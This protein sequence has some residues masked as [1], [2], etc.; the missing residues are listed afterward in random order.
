MHKE[1]YRE[2]SD[3]LV[4]RVEKAYS[5][6][7]AGKISAKQFDQICDRAEAEQ[8]KNTVSFKTRQYANKFAA[9][10]DEIGPGAAYRTKG[11]SSEKWQPPGV[12]DCTQAQ[13]ESLFAAASAK[14]PSYGVTVK[15]GGSFADKALT[16][17]G[18]I[19]IKASSSPTGEGIAG[20]GGSL[21][22]P[23][24]L[25]QAFEQRFEPDR[26]FKHL[27]GVAAD[28]QWVSFLKHV[29]N[30]NPA[31]PSPEFG[32]IPDVGMNITSQ[33]VTF[34]RVNAMCTFSIEL[35]TDFSEFMSFVPHELAKAVVD[36]ETNFI[37][38]N[39]DTTYGQ[40]KG[41]LHTSDVLTRDA[42]QSD[43]PIDAVVA[44]YNDIR[45]GSSYGTADIVAMHPSTWLALRTVRSS[46]GLYVLDQNE[47]NNLGQSYDTLFGV[48]II[49]NSWIPA[50][51]AIVMDAS[52]GCIGWTRQGL[53]LMTNWA[54]D[55]EFSTYAWSF[56]AVER[57]A[58]GVQRPTAV[59]IVSN[60]PT[61]G[62]SS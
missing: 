31:T 7:T 37:V 17:G 36:S 2:R 25:P 30:T 13:W 11:I 29:S 23:V 9:G 62:W 1:T 50:G 20:A 19:R 54:G 59:C 34:T 60:L 53:E 15:A 47:P 24:L 45:V 5:D 55:N 49:Q 27:P 14:M 12:L 8:E 52:I 57:I 38:N 40:S 21:L 6:F 51:T 10:P 39:T 44:A 43:T 16:G 3:E 48:R 46:T 56:R 35:L 26:L 4:A 61:G 42:T 58:I 32:T 22:P 41:L 33:Q 28:G 18:D